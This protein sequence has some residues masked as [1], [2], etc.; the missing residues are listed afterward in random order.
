M[1][2][3]RW[4]VADKVIMPTGRPG[5]IVEAYSDGGLRRIVVRYTDTTSTEIADVPN[6]LPRIRAQVR[7]E[8]R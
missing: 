4:T 5:V 6:D 2:K 8:Y 3:R 1:M 7:A